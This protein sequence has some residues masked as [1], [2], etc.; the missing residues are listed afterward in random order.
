M[1]TEPNNVETNMGGGI[2]PTVPLTVR[3]DNKIIITHMVVRIIMDTSKECLM[4]EASASPIGVPYRRSINTK[5]IF[6]I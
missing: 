6:P 3:G 1:R 5:D 2:N 4:V